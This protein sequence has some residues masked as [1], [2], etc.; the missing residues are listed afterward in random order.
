[1]LKRIAIVVLLLALPLGPVS[2]AP[3]EKPYKEGPVTSVTYMR[4]EDGK[5]NAYMT[6]LSGPW[7]QLQES[8][9]KAGVITEYHVF[10]ASPR[11]PADPNVILTVTYP[12][13]AA[14]DRIDDID[15]AIVKTYGSLKD[16][17]K[18]VVERGAIRKE[19]GGEL[20][21]EMVFK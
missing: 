1:M 13:H 15:A 20:I 7:R 3:E 14:L 19:L 5:F 16:A 21:Q 8:L 2:A 6:Y 11:S 10:A 9:K 17:D 4:V 18:G 12:N